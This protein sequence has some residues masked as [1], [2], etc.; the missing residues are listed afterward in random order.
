ML[1]LIRLTR[2]GSLPPLDPDICRV[3]A[4]MLAELSG[5]VAEYDPGR[6]GDH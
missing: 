6:E 5:W 4:L 2:D 3:L 1:D